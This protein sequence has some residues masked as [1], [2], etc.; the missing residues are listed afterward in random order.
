MAAIRLGSNTF[1]ADND[2]TIIGI[3]SAGGLVVGGFGS[4]PAT[5]LVWV[6]FRGRNAYLNADI[7][8]ADGVMVLQMRDNTVSLNADNVYSAEQI[9]ADDGTISRL[10]VTNQ[11]GE[12]ALNLSRDGSVW[13]F[14]CDVYCRGWHVVATS[15]GMTV[16]PKNPSV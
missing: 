11:F 12:T 5:R 3:D 6:T 13:D 8:D 7:T 10:V 14:Q 1:S 9:P 4:P 16:N 15:T 2:F